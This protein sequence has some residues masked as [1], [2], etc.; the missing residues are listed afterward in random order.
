MNDGITVGA[1]EFDDIQKM[2]FEAAMGELEKVVRKLENGEA[3]LEESID[4]YTRGEALKKHCEAKLAEAEAR[5][6]KITL[7]KDG[8]PTGVEPFEA[9]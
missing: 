1:S 6:E 9:D 2:S 5:I 8:S 3:S 7:A 4:F